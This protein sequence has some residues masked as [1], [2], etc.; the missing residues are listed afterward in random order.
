[1][2][3]DERVLFSKHHMVGLSQHI[4]YKGITSPYNEAHINDHAVQNKLQH[5][6]L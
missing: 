4:L 1:M 6:K 5:T 3:P 2:T